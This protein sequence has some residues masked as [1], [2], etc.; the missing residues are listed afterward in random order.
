MRT[1]SE[2]SP[3]ERPRSGRGKK[4]VSQRVRRAGV[5]AALGAQHPQEFYD[6]FFQ[7]RQPPPPA[8][9]LPVPNEP[10]FE[11]APHRVLGLE[12]GRCSC[13][14]GFDEDVESIVGR[15]TGW[16]H[17]DAGI[18]LGR[19]LWTLVRH[20]Q[21]EAVVETGVARGVTSA[22]ILRAMR[23]NGKGRLWSIDLPPVDPDW[24]G[25]S[26]IAVLPEDRSSWTYVRGSTRRKLPLVLGETG[27]ID[28]FIHDS[29]HDYRTMQFEYEQA[30]PKIKPQGLLISDDIDDNA[31]WPHFVDKVA[32]ERAGEV[33]NAGEKNKI[34]MIGLMRRQ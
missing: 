26:G 33:V 9:A 32:A 30:W 29:A 21:P 31:A 25:Q 28:I 4:T 6:R 13:F 22:F 14:E 20:M 8:G 15:L 7:R 2:Q 34:G 17:M 3:L 1:M 18:V 23:R 5:V 19:T 12:P 27:P 16:H 10:D 24:H 11:S